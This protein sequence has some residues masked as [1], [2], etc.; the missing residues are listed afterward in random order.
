M[1]K[2]VYTTIAAILI[3]SCLNIP[4]KAQCADIQSVANIPFQFSVGEKTLPAGQ[5]RV[6]C[7]NSGYGAGVIHLSNSNGA[8]GA[9]AASVTGKAKDHARLVF[10]RYGDRY[11]LVQ[12]WA[13]GEELGLEITKSRA[14]RE[15]QRELATVK[16]SSETVALIAGR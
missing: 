8:V 4:A 6:T 7:M 14:E 10:H 12:A 16:P 5:Y 9:T 11:F 2:Q 1:K 3:T 13:A 15:L